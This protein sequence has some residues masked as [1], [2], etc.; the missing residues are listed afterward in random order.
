MA[1]RLH[2]TGNQAWLCQGYLL[3]EGSA[4]STKHERVEPYTVPEASPTWE[5]HGLTSLD[6]S[7]QK[8]Q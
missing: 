3:P 2:K 6:A 8:K 1:T 5:P 4:P 7:G